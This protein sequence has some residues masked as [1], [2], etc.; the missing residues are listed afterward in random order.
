[1]ELKNIRLSANDEKLIKFLA[2]FKLMLAVDAKKFYKT[3]YY[4]KRL[5]ALKNANYITRF[6]KSYI[7][8]S[9]ACL[10]LL[11]KENIKYFPPCKN[12]ESIDRYVIVSKIGIELVENQ[13]PYKLSWEMK[14]D[15]Y[16]DWSRRFIAEIELRG[17]KYLTYYAK[18]NEKYIRAMQFDINKD[19]TYSNILVISD[20][21]DIIKKSSPFVFPNKVSV[22]IINKNRINTLYK[23]NKLNI[24]EEIEKIYGKKADDPD[25]NSAE[26]KIDSK[27]I[28]FM[29]YLDTHRILAI[30]NLYTLGFFEENIEILTFK[31][32]I[33][34]IKK[35]INESFVDKI[36]YKEIEEKEFEEKKYNLY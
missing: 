29:P 20:N 11:E 24:K 13:I 26:Y 28:V 14:G 1:M 17:E 12:K 10:R 2:R 27:N 16:T 19:V 21:V 15:S 34:V 32:N 23:F 30:N 31:E 36:S 9:G 18:N 7:K 3:S 8:L 4:Q 35:L 6:H 22:L 33:K 5:Q 25:F